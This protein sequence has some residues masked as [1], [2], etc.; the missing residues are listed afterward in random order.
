MPTF[1]DSMKPWHDLY[2][3]VGTASATLVGLLFVA[4]SVG[5]R[6]ASKETYPALRVFISPSVV[7]FTCVF[8]ACLVAVSPIPS[9]TLA[10]ALVG[11]VGVFGLGYSAGVWLRMVKLGYAASLD[12]EDHTYYAAAP[13]LIHVAFTGTGVLLAL[14][15]TYGCALLALALASLLAVGIRNAWDI[16]LWTVARSD[17]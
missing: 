10:G 14:R 5:S 17:G 16:T 2:V 4:A 3:L 15:L 6:Y 12:L 13:A 11:G 7:H 8:M 1:L 9:W